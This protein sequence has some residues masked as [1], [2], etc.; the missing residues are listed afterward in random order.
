MLPIE[1]IAEELGIEKDYLFPYGRYITKIDH[2]LLKNLKDKDCGKL[3]LVTAIT[4]TPAGEGKTT[5]SIGLSMALNLLGKKSVVTLREPSLG[6]TLGLKGGATGG[7]KS[8]V[9]PANEINLHFT[10]DIHAVASAHNLL[11]AIIDSHIKHGNELGIDLTKIFWKR[12]MDMNDRSL[13]KI[14]VGLG[15][16]PNGFPRED[17][18]IITAASEIMAIL[19]LAKDL[20]DLKERIGRIVVALNSKGE[21]IKASDL[22]IQGAMTVL[23]KDALNPNLVQTSEGTPAFVH[24][25]PFANIAHGTNSLISTEL[26]LRLGEYTVT[27]SGFGA[28]LGAEKFIDFVSRVGDLYPNVVVIVATIR[29][30]KYHGGVDLKNVQEKN[31]EALE[32]GFENLKVHVENL[33]KFNLPVV[34][35]LNKFETDTNKEISFVAEKCEKLGVKVAISEVFEKGGEGGLDLAKLVVES[36]TNRKPSFLYDWE[37]PLEKKI[38]V[39]AKEIY[40]AGAVEYTDE[41]RKALRFIKKHGFEG[42]PIIVAKTPKSISHDPKLRGAPKDYTF[43]VRDAYVSAGAGFIV[44]LSGDVNL[45]P[46]L[47]KNPNA[48]SMDVDEDGNILNVL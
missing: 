32:R 36:V 7:G 39:L 18:F 3:V 13:R 11:S 4:P 14:V 6:P 1:K 17:G 45:M 44:I 15:G 34:V 42:L 46:G 33:K 22:N 35:A 43:V 47:P 38:E 2:R 41:A 40:R 37:D 10:G 28:D 12:T 30:L 21:L 26:A 29:A 9:L 16:S 48:L 5:T 24:G 25:G 20:K 23:L 8:R 31:I 27:E 19:S